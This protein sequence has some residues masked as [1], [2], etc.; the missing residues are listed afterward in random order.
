MA[1]GP[2]DVAVLAELR[3]RDATR[4]ELAAA[5]G[6]SKPTISEAIVSLEAAGLVVNR[7][8]TAGA[9]GRNPRVYAINARASL[10][11]GVDI[12]GTNTRVAVADLH[13]QILAERHERTTGS[14]VQQQVRRL[15]RQ[16]HK[17]ATAVLGGDGCALASIVVSTPGV[18]DRGSTQARF[19][20]NVRTDGIIDLTALRDRLDPPLRVENNVNL[21][22]VGEAR[23]G[24]AEGVGTFVHLAIGAGIGLGIMHG[25]RLL[26]GAHGAAGEIAYLPLGRRPLAKEHRASGNFEAETA[27]AGLL[28]RAQSARWDAD[29]PQ[30]VAELFHRAEQGDRAA[31]RLVADEGRRIGLAVVAVCSVVDPELVV[32]GGG[33]GRNQLLLESVSQTCAELLPAP[34]PVVTSTLADRGSLIGAVLSAVD[35]AWSLLQSN[36]KEASS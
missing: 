36:P 13:G 28:D 2:R 23:A 27:A 8:R 17:E 7:G 19:A 21:A 3:L 26:R 31:R 6:F 16:V 15:I 22:A 10:V 9:V 1:M 20:Y 24:V 14:R 35:D 18:I 32:L 5:T 33:I 25:G 29:P 11:A 30:D 4:P 12:G 34:S